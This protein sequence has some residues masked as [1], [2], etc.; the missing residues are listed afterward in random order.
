[1]GFPFVA[2]VLVLSPD[3]LVIISMWASFSAPALSRTDECGL[4]PGRGALS[5]QDGPE[6]ERKLAWTDLNSTGSNPW[7]SDAA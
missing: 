2:G 4:L 6:L 5:A 7:G 3:W 1:M